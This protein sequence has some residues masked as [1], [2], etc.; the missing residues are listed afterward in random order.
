MN[1]TKALKTKKKLV[2]QVDEAYTR[3]LA[4]NSHEA[5]MSTPYDAEESF[6]A[7][8]DLTKQLIDLKTKIQLANAPIAEKIFRLGE[9][10][11]LSSRM[12]NVDV[13]E[14]K[15]RDRYTTEGA[16]IEYA[17]FMNI[18]AKD[19]Q[20]KEW[21]AEIENLQEEIEAFNAITKI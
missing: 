16:Y 3:F 11:N 2:K 10:K 5:S 17:A 1:L 8:L 7:W 15:H 12:R 18:V 9:L 14:G 13:K 6:N 20:V 21:E 19:K 4:F